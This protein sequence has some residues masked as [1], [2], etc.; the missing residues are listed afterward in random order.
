MCVRCGT[1]TIA[2]CTSPDRHAND[3]PVGYVVACKHYLGTVAVSTPAA[4]LDGARDYVLNHLDGTGVILAVHADGSMT[5][6]ESRRRDEHS[7]QTS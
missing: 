1:G 5:A 6:V 7:E 4:T 3:E 2:W